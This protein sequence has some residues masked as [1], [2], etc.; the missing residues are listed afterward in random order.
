MEMILNAFSAFSNWAWGMPLT[1]VL[2]G[3]G[4]F[5]TII[6]KGE[7]FYRWKF[8]FS[9]TYG[10][11][12]KKADG[13]GTVSSFAAACTAMA[14]TIGTGN[15]AGVSTAIASGGPGAVVW[16]WVTGLLGCSTKAA[17]IIIGQR[18]RVRYSHIDE[19]TCSRE[20]ALKQTFGLKILPF[21][22]AALFC[23]SSP[24]TCLV[25]VE[26]SVSSWAAAVSGDTSLIVT[27]LFLGSAAVVIF[28]GLRRISSWME[29][30]VPFM[31]IAYILG[32][33]VIMIMN[34]EMILPTFASIFKGVFTPQ[35]AAGGFAGATVR[36]AMRYGVARGVYS[37]DAG[38]GLGL[39]AHSPAKVDHPIRQ[40]CWGWGEVFVDTCVVC[41]MS[42]LA[43]L[44]TN[45]YQ[46][47][48]DV[49]TSNYVTA[50]FQQTL[51]TGG[52]VF[53]AIVITAFS[54]TTL[55]GHYYATENTFKGII[56]DKPWLRTALIVFAVYYILPNIIGG[57]FDADLLWGFSDVLGVVNILTTSAL[58]FG[59]YKEIIRLCKDFNERFQPAIDRG[60]NPEPV[61]FKNENVSV[62]PFS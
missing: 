18:Y 25:Q 4:L 44:T 6:T 23:I 52:A 15:I 9:N 40:G 50:A 41:T 59:N 28:G 48:E 20:L 32:V 35:A 58:I 45:V 8:C 12:F 46:T 51:G 43:I 49:S 42:A 31:S 5:S 56:G 11:I 19:Y 29:K 57:R 16:M 1:I 27:V 14:N 36:D 34:A 10:K 2:L 33:L 26:A 21:L 24:W 60:E 55:I 17:E 13:V 54:W 61:V 3:T 47:A 62:S 7:F 53:A 22:L 37:N 39:I 30:I 38:S